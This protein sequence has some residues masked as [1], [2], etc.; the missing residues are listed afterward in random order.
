MGGHTSFPCHLNAHP[1]GNTNHHLHHQNLCPYHHPLASHRRLRAD[2]EALYI[3]SVACVLVHRNQMRV[4]WHLLFLFH[5]RL[6]FRHFPEISLFFFTSFFLGRGGR[7]ALP[8][9]CCCFH[10]V[11][12]TASLFLP[13]SFYVCDPSSCHVYLLDTYKKSPMTQTWRE[14][15]K[16]IQAKHQIPYREAQKKAS[17]LWK[18]KPSYEKKGKKY[19]TLP[20][21]QKVPEISQFPKKLN[22]KPKTKNSA[23][24]ITPKMIKRKVPDIFLRAPKKKRRF[25][26]GV[27]DASFKYSV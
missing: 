11:L 8:G 5:H 3:Q 22:F 17:G 27:D 20:G 1:S 23:V 16:E 25:T 26:E 12:V 24:Y 7:F 13:S 10:G 19:K 18:K 2:R 6:H 14:F 15:V 21:I 9:F 4:G